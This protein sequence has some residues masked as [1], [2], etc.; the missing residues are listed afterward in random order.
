MSGSY[1]YPGIYIQELPSSSHAVVP[2]PT[3]IA[4][5]VGY[6]H[7]YQN[8]AGFGVAKQ[9]FSF[10]DYQTFFGGL[11]SSGLTDASLPRAVYQFF[12]NGGSTAWIVGLQP[13]LFKEGASSE[14]ALTRLGAGGIYPTS[15]TL[16]ATGGGLIFSALQPI[17]TIP[18]AITASRINSAGTTFDIT[19]TYGNQIEKYRGHHAAREH[20]AYAGDRPGRDDQRQV[21]AHPG[22]CCER[23]IRFGAQP[24]SAQANHL[25]GRLSIIHRGQLRHRVRCQRL[26]SCVPGEFLARQCRDLQSAARSRG[27]RQRGAERRARVRGTQTAFAIVDPP[28]Q[29][30]AFDAGRNDARG[31]SSTG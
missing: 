4:A 11:F 18:M 13:G 16:A 25:D 21:A 20:H 22:Q 27:D 31:R 23:W 29:A 2:A 10:N 8:T 19:V 1:S 24:Q 12:L 14:S 7:P 26:H 5:F 6:S 9:I 3:S 15:S 17:D 28:P 30:P